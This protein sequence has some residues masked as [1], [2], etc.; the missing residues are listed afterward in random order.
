MVQTRWTKDQIK[1]ATHLYCQ[2]PFGKLHQGNKE[3]VALA[4]LIDRTPSAVAMK[5]GNLAS[6]DP[7]ITGTGRS[8][9]GKGSKAD[10][11]VWDEFHG[12]WE[13]LASESEQILVALRGAKAAASAALELGSDE[14]D[15]TGETKRQLV[16]TRVKQAFFRKAVLS[17]Y[18]SKCCM[19]GLAEPRLLQ[20]SHIVPWSQDRA[21]R[22]NPRNGLCLSA[23]H[24]RAFD[25][26]L[27]TVMPDLQIRVSA[28]L[29]GGAKQS[30]AQ[31]TICALDGRSI[32]LPERFL[33][34]AAFLA[35]HNE[36]VFLGD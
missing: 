28:M 23:L 36:R 15:Y 6:L 16:E 5:L 9:L 24:D 3:I 35:W 4:K 30:F 34:D 29:R 10:R 22:L 17:S 31:T 18:G 8:G 33:P 12:D 13:K 25:R 21:N 11:E 2:L 14:L 19:T 20:A 27:I 7:A 1:V 26:G 32:A